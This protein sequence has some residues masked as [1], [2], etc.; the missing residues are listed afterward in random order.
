MS[1][2]VIITGATGMVGRGVL[3]ECLASS[4]ITEVLS[5][6][7][8]ASG[9]NPPKLQEILLP[10]LT[11]I[12]AYRSRLG[13]YDGCFFCMGVSVLGLDE[14]TYT[15]ITFDIVKVFAD[16]LFEES[17]DMVFNYVSGSSTDSTEKGRVMWARVKGRAENYVLAKGFRDAYAFRPGFI[18]PEKGIR[19]RTALYNLLI[20]LFRPFFGMLRKSESITSTDRIGLAMIHSLFRDPGLKHLEN[21]DIN[22]LAS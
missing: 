9:E 17:P 13:G 22:R 18:I 21:R 2:R 19:S 1:Y 12:G 3:L 10:D 6:S 11:E 15:K 4:Q 8:T 20:N 14:K 7:R 5:I 16:V